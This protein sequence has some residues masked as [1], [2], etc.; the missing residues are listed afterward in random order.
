MPAASCPQSPP[1]PEVSQPACAVLLL[2]RCLFVGGLLRF[3]GFLL[4][5]GVERL[6]FGDVVVRAAVVALEL[7]G[8]ADK[9]QRSGTG[10]ALIVRYL[11]WHIIPL[12]R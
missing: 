4:F 2:L 10:R 12:F 9:M 5:F 8:A 7:A 6:N 11:G 1:R 3:G